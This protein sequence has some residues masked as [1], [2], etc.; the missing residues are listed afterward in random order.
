VD[1]NSVGKENMKASTIASLLVSTT[2]FYSFFKKKFSFFAL[3]CPMAN[4]FTTI[5]NIF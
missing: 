1:P 4:L 5:T 3:S 2:L